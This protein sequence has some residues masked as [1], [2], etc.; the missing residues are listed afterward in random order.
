[1]KAP[2]RILVPTDMSAYSLEGLFY[3]QEISKIFNAEII[4]LYVDEHKKKEHKQSDPRIPDADEL[5]TRSHLTSFLINNG[6][7][8]Q[9]LRI[10]IRY[11]SP[12][13]NIVNAAKQLHADLIVLSTHGRTGLQHILMGS[14]A[15][16]VVRYAGVPVLTVKPRDLIELIAITEED[17]ESELHLN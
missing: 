9:D 14:V 11:G 16:K 3:A 12:A 13:T 15:E 5:K 2:E 4:V 7:A 8:G 10:E 1:M 17:I 6:A